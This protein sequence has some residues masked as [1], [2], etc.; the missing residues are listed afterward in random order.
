VNKGKAIAKQTRGILV[1]K[2]RRFAT[3]SF[4]ILFQKAKK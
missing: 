2:N 4:V 3:V 1:S